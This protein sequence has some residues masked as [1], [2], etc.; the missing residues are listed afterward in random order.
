MLDFLPQILKMASSG[1]ELACDCEG[2]ASGLSGKDGMS[3]FTM[4]SKTLNHT[5]VFRTQWI[6]GL[7]DIPGGEGQ[8]LRSLLESKTIVQ[9]GLFSHK[10]LLFSLGA[11]KLWVVNGLSSQYVNSRNSSQASLALFKHLTFQSA[12]SLW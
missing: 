8:T 3:H 2:T 10:G 12:N 5:W 7:F 6:P 11:K 9:V 4:T 1:V